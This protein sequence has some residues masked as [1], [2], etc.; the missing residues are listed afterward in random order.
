VDRVSFRVR[1][2]E[3][4]G[5]LGANGA[6]K[7]TVI[8]M[9][10]GILPPTAG[11]GHVAGADMRH[12]GRDLKQRIGYVSQAFSLYTDLTALENIRLYAGIYGLDAA[13]ARTREAW[14]VEMGGLG[15][16]SRSWP[17]TFRWACASA[18]PGCA[19]VHRPQVSSRQ[20]TSGVDPWAAAS[21]G[22][23]VRLPR[24]E[25]VAILV[26][27]HYMSEANTAIG[28]R[29]CSRSGSS[30]RAPSELKRRWRRPAASRGRH[31]HRCS[32]RIARAGF[33][34]AALRPRI[35][36]SRGPRGDRADPGI[37]A[38]E[39]VRA[40]SVTPLAISMED[41]FVYRIGALEDQAR[42]AREGLP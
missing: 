6:G 21:S 35:I 1:Q 19:L 3:I 15:G 30:R 10:T 32:R 2:G 25:G 16:T 17:G 38:A 37:L 7:T 4:F 27:T 24:E 26:T 5:L 28:W 34:D 13:E 23:S 36:S 8:K 18:T 14:I 31:R 33:G 20:P 41:V 42:A 22:T 11:A 39:G 29:S 9:L 12:A 40:S